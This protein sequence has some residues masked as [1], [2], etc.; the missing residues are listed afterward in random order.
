MLC[1]TAPEDSCFPH[2]SGEEVAAIWGWQQGVRGH[3]TGQDQCHRLFG[4]P[5]LPLH[6]QAVRQGAVSQAPP[7]SSIPSLLAASEMSL[8]GDLALLNLTGQR[9]EEKCMV[10]FACPG[11]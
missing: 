3:A 2:V 5:A 8:V 10:H 4:F 6:L 11:Q 7:L 1:N 9:L